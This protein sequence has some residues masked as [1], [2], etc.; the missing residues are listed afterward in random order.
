MKLIKIEDNPLRAFSAFDSLEGEYLILLKS[1]VTGIFVCKG[2]DGSIIDYSNIPKNINV[3]TTS[4]GFG[5][6]YSLIGYSPNTYAIVGRVK[7][8]KLTRGDILDKMITSLS[9]L[10][11]DVY[12]DKNSSGNDLLY[13]N[14]KVLGLITEKDKEYT[15]FAMPIQGSIDDNL[16]NILSC[17][18]YP[19]VK[20]K[21]KSIME[22]VGELPNL[23]NRFDEL[24]ESIKLNWGYDFKEVTNTE[25]KINDKLL[26]YP[27][28]GE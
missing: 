25:W 10:E 16:I 12:L 21:G 7:D 2:S 15:Y 28:V 11:Y 26:L 18:K 17:I 20:L 5:S 23:E 24:Y 13:N 4:K 8:V 6:K 27:K 22:R 1:N 14:K 19:Q 3:I 9:Y